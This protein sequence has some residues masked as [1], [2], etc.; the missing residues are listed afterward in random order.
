MASNVTVPGGNTPLST[1][2][3]DYNRNLAPVATQ[4][5]SSIYAAEANNTLQAVDNP[6]ASPTVES[7][8]AIALIT[9]SMSSVPTGFSSMIIGATS[10]PG[11]TSNIVVNNTNTVSNQA[12]IFGTAGGYL[13]TGTGQGTIL[14]SLGANT[15]MGTG[16]N[17]TIQTDGSTPSIGG[18]YIKGQTSN[19]VLNALG[20]DTYIGGT[21]S[22][23]LAA[24]SGGSLFFGG[25][26]GTKT[27]FSNN[28]RAGSGDATY[29]GAAGNSTVYANNVNG[30]YIFQSGSMAFV[31]GS[32]S[33]TM[34]GGSGT[35]TLFAGTGNNT[36]VLGSGQTQFMAT[37]GNQVIFGGEAQNAYFSNNAFINLIGNNTGGNQLIALGGNNTLSTAFSSSNN[38]LQA[39]SGNDQLFSGSGN[40]TFISGAGGASTMF[41]GGGKDV[42]VL[43]KGMQGATIWEFNSSSLLSLN[44]WGVDAENAAVTNQASIDVGG[45]ASTRLTLND[46]TTITLV[47][48]NHLNSGQVFNS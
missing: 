26:A 44:G 14:G 46:N 48:V 34:F 3:L 39:G 9:S 11:V 17:W 45:L 6:T 43:S 10:Q 1:V 19:V 23:T 21:G 27:V 8:N 40:D 15:I 41:G 13:E 36:F 22:A 5:L 7:S 47:G 16:G 42:F 2:S 33:N 35:A 30:S 24:F 37:G 18:S 31:S 25:K 32:G 29:V 4:L 28:S 12:V 20:A 38:I